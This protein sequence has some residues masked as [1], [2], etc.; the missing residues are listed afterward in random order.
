M[1]L[2]IGF[3]LAVFSYSDAYGYPFI[4]STKINTVLYQK[5]KPYSMFK[6]MDVYNEIQLKIQSK[7][8]RPFILNGPITPLKKDFVKNLFESD[9]IPFTEYSFN[10]FLYEKPFL[11]NINTVIYV[12][13]YMIGQGRIF[14]EEEKEILCYFPK[15]LNYI[16]FNADNIETMPYQ[17]NKINCRFEHLNFPFVSK[18][19]IVHHIYDIITKNEYNDDMYCIDWNYFD[20]EILNL[21]NI[22]NLLKDVEFLLKK[23]M[24]YNINNFQKIKFHIQKMIKYYSMQQ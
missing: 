19:D 16:I 24:E 23:E 4:D 7:D 12:P 13:D 15:S 2:Y 10:K 6:R 3:I 8:T 11:F 5:P 21:K 20:I 17:D 18:K 9:Y 22:D 1:V 14:N